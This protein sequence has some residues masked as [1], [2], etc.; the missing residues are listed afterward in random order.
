MM[1]TT[2]NHRS[3]RIELVDFLSGDLVISRMMNIFSLSAL[4]WALLT[5]TIQCI[6]VTFQEL[7]VW[8]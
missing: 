3:V 6:S 2:F 8:N 5:V 4:A 7:T 1:E